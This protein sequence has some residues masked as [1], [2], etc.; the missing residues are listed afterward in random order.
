M[1]AVEIFFILVVLGLVAVFLLKKFGGSNKRRVKGDAVK[2]P[3]EIESH[4][5]HH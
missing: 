5:P 2:S 4:R 1:I 3:E